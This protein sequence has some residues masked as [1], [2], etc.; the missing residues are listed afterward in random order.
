MRGTA[1]SPAVISA[2]SRAGAVG[3]GA[4]R[5]ASALPALPALPACAPTLR[6]TLKLRPQRLQ[7]RVDVLVAALDLSDVVDHGIAL[8]R[9]R[10]EQHRHAGADVGAFHVLAPQRRR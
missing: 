5:G 1:A 3:G 10:G 8:S 6:S 4:V 9:Q 2:S 7:A